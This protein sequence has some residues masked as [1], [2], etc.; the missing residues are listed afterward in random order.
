M[1]APSR[2]TVV[3]TAINGRP[4]NHRPGS[5]Q[6]MSAF[7]RTRNPMSSPPQQNGTEK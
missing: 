2:V 4:R 6:I 1:T 7:A 3:F 5:L